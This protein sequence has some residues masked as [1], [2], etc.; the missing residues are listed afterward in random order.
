MVD[1]VLAVG[2]MAFQRKCIGKMQ[3]VGATG[4]TVL[5]VSHDLTAI[6]RLAPRTLLL[7]EGQVV[8]SGSTED[9]VRL[10]SS[11]Q[12]EGH[13]VGARTDRQGDGLI[14]VD[15]IGF[16]DHQQRTVTSIASGEEL[17]VAIGYTSE[18]PTIRYEDI[19]LDVVMTDALG[20]PVAT[21]STRFCRRRGASLLAG[22]GT[23]LCHLPRVA[24]AE[25]TYGLDVWMAYRGGVTDYVT[26]AQELRVITG[27]FFET[28]QEPVKRKHGAALIPHEWSG[29]SAAASE[30]PVGVASVVG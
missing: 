3:D 27:R 25:E 2:D 15:S 6:S 16:L 26:R 20:H 17:T 7:H 28:G 18:M 29:V 4:Q 1:E 14:R 5:F 30:L 21:L 24:L 11:Q 12:S 22:C 19:S 8:F 10:Y 23:L 9:A 13:R